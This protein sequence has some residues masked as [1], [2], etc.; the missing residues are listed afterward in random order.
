MS[1]V[2]LVSVVLPVRYVRE[3]WLRQ[4]IESVLRQDYPAKELIV[5]N[6]EATSDID[7]MVRGYGIGKYIKNGRNRGLPYSLNRGFE[8]AS[9][10]LH[11]WTSADNYMLPGMLTALAG[12]LSSCP[13]LDIAY[14][15]AKV[16]NTATG[17]AGGDSLEDAVLRKSGWEHGDTAVPKLRSYLGTLGACFLYRATVW[18]ELKGYDEDLHGAEDFDF[19]VRAARSFKAGLLPAPDP[20]YVYRVHGNSMSAEVKGC[21]SSMRERILRREISAHPEDKDLKRALRH[22]HRNIAISVL[23]GAVRRIERAI[24]LRAGA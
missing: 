1:S 12:Y 8:Q 2:P 17:K 14:G 11:T 19:W 18:K 7:S 22:L 6:D 3:D 21:F 9:G 23:R 24:S 10:E 13:S 20:F 5:V 15:R 16:L 4:S